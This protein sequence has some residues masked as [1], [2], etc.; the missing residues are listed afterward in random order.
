MVSYP[1]LNLVDSTIDEVA[2]E[3]LDGITLEALWQRLASRFHD[4]LP[5]PKA[6]LTQIWT[7]CVKVRE[8]TFYALEVP[9]EPLVIFDRYEFVDPDLGTILEPEI[10]PTDVYPHSPVQDTVNGNK[11]SCSTYYTRKDVSSAVKQLS[12]EEAVEKYGQCLVIVASQSTRERALMG[13]GVC[14]TLELNITQ[15]CFL[16]RVGRSRYHGEVTQGKLSLSALKE[17]PKSLFYH[18]KYLLRHKLITKQ[19]HHQKSSGHSYNG[20]LLH[21]P[22]FF[23]ERKPKVLFLAEQVINILKSKD[24]YVAEYDEIKRKLQIENSIK[25]LYKTSFFQ[26]VVK[27]D[28]RVPYRTLYPNAKPKEW[29]LKNNANKE[30]MIRVVQLLV[31]DIDIMEVWN[32]DETP[33]E[34][35][36]IDMDVSC[37]KLNV[38][39]LKQ[40]NTIIE[41]SES[42]GVCQG[43][44]SRLM[45]V[46]KLQSRTLLRNMVKANIVATYMN[47]IGRQRLAKF[48]AK[49]FEKGS[50]LSKQFKTEMHKIK[51]FR[52]EAES[53][54]LKNKTPSVQKDDKNDTQPCDINDVDQ[55]IQNSEELII[56]EED[57]SPNANEKCINP[58]LNK[59]FEMVNKILRKYRLTRHCIKYKRTGNTLN[60]I[61]MKNLTKKTR[62]QVNQKVEVLPAALETSNNEEA[63]SLY[64][65]IKTVL[66]TQKPLTTGKGVDEAL[67]LMDDVRNIEKKNIANVT[68]RLLRRANMIIESVKEHQV[69]V[70]MTR[71]MKMIHEEEDKE[72]YDVKIDKKSLIRLLQKL[73]KD[74]LIKSIRLTLSANGREKSMTFI[75]D[76]NVTT[77]HTVIKSAVEQEK[78]KFCLMGTHKVRQAVKKDL[79]RLVTPKDSSQ[80]T[81]GAAHEQETLPKKK[82]APAP[83][84]KYDPRAAKKYGFSP[85]FIRMQALHILLYYL[86]YDHPGEQKLSKSEQIKTLRDNGFNIPDS[87]AQE[88]STVYTADVGWRMFVPPLPKHKGWP[89]GWALMSDILLRIPLSIF[90]KVHHVSFMI[91]ELDDYINHPIRKHY[92]VRDLTSS[93]RNT[94]LASRKYIFNIHQTATRLCY[95]GLL[96][97]GP[98]R[99]KEKDQVFLYVNHCTEL[100]D[101]T[102]SAP[103]YHKIEEKSYPVM[104]YT[105]DEMQTVEKYWYDMWN[106]CINTPLGG[107]LVVQGKDILLE[108]L[109]KK[110]DMI[111]AILA[112]SPEE[113]ARLDTGEVP[114]DRKGAAGTDSAMFA[115][116]KRNWNWSSTGTG[117]RPVNRPMIYERHAYLSKIKAKP[118]KFTEFSGL[119]KVSGPATVSATELQQRGQR[120]KD[121]E[122]QEKRYEALTSVRSSK[123]KSFVRRVQP[124]KQKSRPRTK[125]D[126]VD[127]RALQRMHK[128]R[129]D[130]EPHEDKIL[131][132]CKVAMMYL[133]PNPRK[134]MVTF[135]TVRDVLRTYSYTSYNKTSRACQR[136]LLYM[137]R[138]PQTV[139]SVALGIEEIKQN[140]FVGR[141]FEGI[142]ERMKEESA[143]SYEYEKRMAEVFK[144]LV[145]YIIKRYYDI[146]KIGP[147]EPLPVPKTIQEFNLFYKIVHPA[148]PMSNRGFVKD[149]KNT[150]DIHA[151]TIN[152]VIHS[153]MCCG[154]DRRSWAYQLFK[155]YQQYSESL[156]R[157]AMTRI[158]ADQMVTIKKHHL[159]TMK[160]YGNY[161]PMSSSQYQLSTTYVYKFHTKWPYSIFDESYAF[162]EKLLEGYCRGKE[163]KTEVQAVTGGL[164]AAVHDFMARDQVDFD[165]EI[166]DQVIMLDPRLKE[167]D[168]TYLRIA[169]RYQDIFASIDRLQMGRGADSEGPR[170]T[171]EFHE[172]RRY[173]KLDMEEDEGKEAFLDLDFEE[174]KENEKEECKDGRVFDYAKD[175][176]DCETLAYESDEENLRI[177]NIENDDQNVIKFQDG[178]KII[179]CSDDVE[180]LTSCTDEDS[181]MELERSALKSGASSNIGEADGKPVVDCES[182]D[183][184]KDGGQSV[185]EKNTIDISVKRRTKDKSMA[186]DDLEEKRL[187]DVNV[188][189]PQDKNENR[190]DMSVTECTN[191][192]PRSSDGSDGPIEK[193]I[194]LEGTKAVDVISKDDNTSLRNVDLFSEET[195][196]VSEEKSRVIDSEES[197]K[198]VDSQSVSSTV[199]KKIETAENTKSTTENKKITQSSREVRKRQK[200]TDNLEED[201]TIERSS[202]KLRKL[203]SNDDADK[204]NAEDSSKSTHSQENI[205]N[206]DKTQAILKSKI[207]EENTENIETN[208]TPVQNPSKSNNLQENT[209]NL[210]ESSL[211][212]ESKP[213][214]STKNIDRSKTLEDN[215]SKSQPRQ[216]DAKSSKNDQSVAEDS[217]EPGDSQENPSKPKEKQA[218]SDSTEPEQNPKEKQI[219]ADLKKFQENTYTRVSD[220]L[221]NA[222]VDKSYS[223]PY[224]ITDGTSEVTKRYTRIAL[225]RMREELSELTVA[226]SHHAHEYFVVNMFKIS[227][228]LQSSDCPENTELKTLKNYSIP[229][230]LLPLELN[231]VEDLIREVKEFATFP[232]DGPSYNDCKKALLRK[233]PV[234]ANLLDTV[235]KFIRDKKEFGASVP[236]LLE[237]FGSSLENKLYTIVTILTRERLFLRSGVTTVRYIHHRHAD[238]WLINSYKI[239]R[240]E[241]ESLPPV[242]RGSVYVTES[243]TVEN[244]S[245]DFE[246]SLEVHRDSISLPEDSPTKEDP[247][248]TRIVDEAMAEEA[249]SVEVGDEDQKEAIEK[250]HQGDSEEEPSVQ[251]KRRIQRK[252]T[253]LLPQRDICRA[254]KQLDF[255]TA[256]E[257]RVAIKPWIRIDGVLNRRVLD[258]MLGSV[259]TYCLTHPGITLAKIQSRYVPA[260]QPF[261]TRE[262]VEMLIK[263][264]CL[265]RK[266]LQRTVVTLFSK[267]SPVNPEKA[268]NDWAAEDEIMLEPVMGATLKFGIFL[269]TKMYTSGFIP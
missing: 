20:S 24:N 185:L 54:P 261:H 132:V 3:G 6:F 224:L 86:V 148:K 26:K 56:Q 243:E 17:D 244:K 61:S 222:S 111:R 91:P 233:L 242:P 36:I 236:E 249:A 144:S 60:I 266:R 4:P 196:S 75:C 248:D 168:E 235:Y 16:E 202:S 127:Y 190:K 116:L 27:T 137:F 104:R 19:I 151:A 126:E 165:I 161:M 232:K 195:S 102:S 200:S 29:Q 15:Y 265:E 103:G 13:V 41:A 2:L 250:P 260:L 59:I 187:A 189:L 107:W 66:V 267:P 226:D 149:V 7:I 88:F 186:E 257:I 171:R 228:G 81:E 70:D 227:Y 85:K 231:V 238:P 208:K 163:E 42:E 45:G 155:I 109:S 264:G 134:Q 35:E 215:S 150:N 247:S 203:D 37:H 94:M 82:A 143:N 12:L 199:S 21:L 182:K 146:S 191:K 80:E 98:Q 125:Y 216:S 212:L 44:L 47:D 71:L 210:G 239:Y 38:P 89:E 138:Q 23:V 141:R 133:C 237:K 198:S 181:V 139:N 164:I 90:L 65:N 194:R 167:K 172:N 34:E 123:Q 95:V 30:K 225:L 106:T 131:L 25:K 112:R 256:E 140:F 119:Q 18:R 39:Y 1:S 78:V 31:P 73:V 135:T 205:D 28:I 246:E 193:K 156:L 201:E 147:R 263:I 100:L 87:L 188:A 230:D 120:G 169:Q 158:R 43:H 214:E 128:L 211:I 33:E 262:L 108:D 9:R 57:I 219:T 218:S 64:K 207:Q 113:A 259:L 253:R 166:P 220:I 22:R 8:F 69:I 58:E 84:Y 197:A 183:T 160:K 49:K 177:T 175:L 96:Q 241:K 11:G 251:T 136:R 258:R 269:S 234:D 83:H 79:D 252:R 46:T 213:Q 173:F 14:P 121:Q 162:F 118:P 63:V 74:N 10:V 110:T 52:D 97:F 184:R 67:G 268:D 206:I 223:N 105:F 117:Q 51:Q 221:R 124:R 204:S 72:G 32:K 68:Y 114:G 154:K 92:L 178:T 129:V 209:D 180:H 229:K 40:A 145:E 55:S 76:P 176:A 53:D 122:V 5:L 255:T 152:S 179:L 93:L 254:A 115:H 153:S 130:W 192:R 157:N 174:Q 101:T 62:V 159:C 50:K 48:V 99:L 245:S 142:T 240:L 77:E 217:I 170:S